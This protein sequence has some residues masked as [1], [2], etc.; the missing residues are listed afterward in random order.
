M[1]ATI[2]FIGL[3]ILF[4]IY[5]FNKNIQKRDEYIKNTILGGILL[6]PISAAILLAAVI[7]VMPVALFAIILDIRGK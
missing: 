7:S 1:F 2:Y 3:I 5:I 4:T 6:W